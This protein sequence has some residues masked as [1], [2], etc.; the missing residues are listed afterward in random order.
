MIDIKDGL[1]IGSFLN[2]GYDITYKPSLQFDYS[3]ISDNEET[4]LSFCATKELFLSCIDE[5]LAGYKDKIIVPISGGL[6]SRALLA[7][8]L[9]IYDSQRIKTY[10]FG[11]EYSYDFEIGSGI[12]KKLGI[13]CRKY[14]LSKFDFTH[15]SLVETARMFDKQ[16]VLFY[17]PPYDRIKSEFGS[18][19]F[20]I[21]FMGDPLAGSH[22]PKNASTGLEEVYSSFHRR[23]K[24]VTSCVLYDLELSSFGESLKPPRGISKRFT[25][26]EYFDFEYRQLK[27]VYPHVMPR[28][29]NCVSP[30]INHRWFSFMMSLPTSFRKEQ[31][32]YNQFL[33]NSFAPAFD[34]PCKN[35]LGLKLSTNKSLLFLWRVM[36]RLPQLK[37][38]MINYQDFNYR[39]CVDSKFQSLIKE[40]LLELEKRNLDLN[41]VPTKLLKMHCEEKP[42]YADALTVLASLEIN[43]R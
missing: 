43:L 14:E 39:L 11:T 33:V 31:K 6:D 22:L 37:R 21:G 8:L 2:F 20:L 25:L 28:E 24:L 35:N 30:F 3:L 7:A 4:P 12:S 38:K 1:S 15:D 19:L 32:F 10:T 9:E 26:D 18:D 42:I 17:H 27:Y 13:E 23:N 36:H 40:L 41:V 16:T 5:S 34:F 29:L